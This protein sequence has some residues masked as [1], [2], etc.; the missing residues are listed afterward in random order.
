MTVIDKSNRI[1]KYTYTIVGTGV[2]LCVFEVAIV[3]IKFI[4]G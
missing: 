4:G 3:F 2:L 1:K